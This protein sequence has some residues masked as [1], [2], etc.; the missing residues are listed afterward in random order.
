LD[1]PASQLYR[2]PSLWFFYMNNSLIHVIQIQEAFALGLGEIQRA[3]ATDKVASGTAQVADKTAKAMH[4]LDSKMRI[5]ERTGNAVGAVKES[6]V[7]QQT[8]A[9][10]TK[11]GESVRNATRKV[12]EQPA[13]S[14]AADSVSAGIRKLTA[15]FSSMTG[16][17]TASDS[18]DAPPVVPENTVSGDP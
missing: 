6:A 5:S 8:G 15:G 1:L 7:M 16:R 11:A 13:V 10:L 2:N 17:H 9:A 4:D 3:R 14:S 12:M 18:T